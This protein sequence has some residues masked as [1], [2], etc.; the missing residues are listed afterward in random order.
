[1][2]RPGRPG[3]AA[4]LRFLRMQAR[5]VIN[6]PVV[7]MPMIRDLALILLLEADGIG[8]TTRGGVGVMC[9]TTVVGWRAE[10]ERCPSAFGNRSDRRR[11]SAVTPRSAGGREDRG[12]GRG[13]CTS[14]RCWRE[15]R[16]RSNGLITSGIERRKLSFAWLD[17]I[18]IGLRIRRFRTSAATRSKDKRQ[19]RESD[20]GVAIH[21]GL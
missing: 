11:R 6:V 16:N 12:K 13:R 8:I 5:T 17:V 7:A 21:L 19:Q 15:L 2:C 1:M 20:A 9:R 18:D 3:S 14:A 10:V 4:F